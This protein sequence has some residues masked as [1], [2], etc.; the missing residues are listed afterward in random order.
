MIAHSG[1]A[2][3]IP[4]TMAFGKGVTELKRIFTLANNNP[5][6]NC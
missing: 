1:L 2:M 3:T 4:E 6:N 5:D